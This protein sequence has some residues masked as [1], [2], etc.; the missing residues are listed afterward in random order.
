MAIS[1]MVSWILKLFGIGRQTSD[2][3]WQITDVTVEPITDSEIESMPSGTGT[4]TPNF[5]TSG[6]GVN[7]TV[8]EIHVCPTCQ[9]RFASDYNLAQHFFCFK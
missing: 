4:G 2:E 5:I 9:R 7:D 8:K 3:I 1:I 6:Y